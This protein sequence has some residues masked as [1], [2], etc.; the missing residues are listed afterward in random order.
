MATGS[1]A[2][3][4]RKGLRSLAPLGRH[5]ATV[6]APSRVARGARGCGT[7]KKKGFYH[8]I[9]LALA[10]AADRR[11]RGVGGVLVRRRFL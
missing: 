7:G 4:A 6:E 3:V 10:P 5:R 8:E 2:D 11:Y 1:K 9:S